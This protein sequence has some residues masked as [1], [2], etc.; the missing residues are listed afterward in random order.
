V[1]AVTKRWTNWK[2]NSQ[3]LTLTEPERNLID[4]TL[5]SLEC[6]EVQL[7]PIGDDF[8]VIF[9]HMKQW[10]KNWSQRIKKTK[11]TDHQVH[12]AMKIKTV[13]NL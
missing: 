6:V 5:M 9:E 4:L 13:K 2:A 10:A 3:P 11:L 7:N 8:A 12:T 1:T